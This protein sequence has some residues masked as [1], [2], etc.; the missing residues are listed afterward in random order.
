MKLAIDFHI[1]TALSP[2]AAEDMTPHNI[3]NMSLLKGLDAIAITDHNSVENCEVCMKV[4]RNKEL[5]VIP[6]MELQTKEE[7]HLVCLFPNIE[8]AKSF[9]EIAYQRL[10]NQK[11]IATVLGRQMIFNEADELIHENNRMLITSV[12]ISIKEAFKEID[13]LGGIIIPAHI[14][15]KSY[16]L[17]INLGFIPSGLPIKTLEISKGCD[18]EKMIER[19][20]YLKG[21]QLIRNSDAHYLSDILERESFIEVRH[22]DIQSIFDTLRGQ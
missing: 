13:Q 18:I 19:Y 3:V 6:G 15:R 10:P 8:A 4:A 9:E 5:L 11:N 12:N 2:C 1:H 16:S 14:D 22:K 21:Y 20:D 17:I 7:I